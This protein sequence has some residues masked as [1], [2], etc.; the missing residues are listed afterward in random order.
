[1]LKMYLRSDAITIL[2]AVNG[3]E[4]VELVKQHP[5]INLVLIDIKMPVMNGFDATRL[6]KK[7]RPELPVIAQTAFTSKED[8][9]KAEKA[10]CDCVILKPIN[11]NELLELIPEL[12]NR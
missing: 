5:E 11:K 12:L 10:G 9:E 7:L 4:A 3:H 2:S 8:R 6:I 1:M